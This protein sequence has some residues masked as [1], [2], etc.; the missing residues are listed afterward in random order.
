MF[1]R[2][3]PLEA[4][5]ASCLT[6][7]T[8]AS[9]RLSSTQ[10]LRSNLSHSWFPLSS[11]L[12]SCFFCY[13]WCW[14]LSDLMSPTAFFSLFKLNHFVFLWNLHPLLSLDLSSACFD[15][16]S[17][18]LECFSCILS[19]WM[20]L[21]L[22]VRQKC[23]CTCNVM[24]PHHPCQC[25]KGMVVRVERLPYKTFNLETGVFFLFPH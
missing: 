20:L 10:A 22:G 5:L 9:G 7:C 17:N 13:K 1:L 12:S 16:T 8:S 24:Q 2:C 14:L 6:R 18:I 19:R 3:I 11:S 4:H 21:G 15:Y 23:T 25:Y